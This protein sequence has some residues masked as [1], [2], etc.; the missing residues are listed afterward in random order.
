MIQRIESEACPPRELMLKFFVKRP[1]ASEVE[2]LRKWIAFGAREIDVP[3]D[4]ATT[5]PDPL[6]TDEDRQHW[7]FQPPTASTNFA[8]LDEFIIDRL[9]QHGLGLSPSADRHTLIRRAYFDL[10]GIPPSLVELDQWTTSD[11]PQWY[12]AMIDHLLASPRYGERWGRYWLDLAGYADSEGGVSADPV[13]QVAWKYRD[14]VIQAFNDDKPY[15]RFLTEQIAGDELLDYENA[16]VVT[17]EMV[18]NLIATGFLRMGIDQ[19]GS[20]TMNF[21]PERL[22]VISDAMTVL[23]SGTMGIT[24]ECARCHSHKYDAIPHRDYYRFKAI[25]QAAFDEYD[26]LSFKTRRLDVATPEHHKR[27]ADVNQPLTSKLKKLDA[28][29][30]KAIANLQTEMLRQHYPQ[31]S[32]ADRSETLRA[33]RIADNNRTRPQRLLVEMLQK[34]EVLPDDEQPP[35]VVEARHA[36]EMSGTRS[37]QFVGRWNHPSPSVHCGIEAIRRRPTSCAAVNTTNRDDS[38][39]RGCRR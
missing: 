24:M 11:D 30:K 23:G 28:E 21:V 18:E 39:V 29:L 38:S 26:W 37:L 22:G 7:A 12:S 13:R 5:A 32:D 27:A 17:E 35:P 3:A 36:V 6:V 14:Y 2:V 34:V 16:D 19:T 1:P 25:F 15:D 10:I 31:Q 33:L 8:T 4:V 20:R 9:G